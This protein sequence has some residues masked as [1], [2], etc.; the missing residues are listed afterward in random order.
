MDINLENE[1]QERHAPVCTSE[2]NKKE[3]FLYKL[4]TSYRVPI[5]R[6]RI[7]SKTSLTAEVSEARADS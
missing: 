6:R 3:T 5:P 2:R 1:G 7:R 4:L